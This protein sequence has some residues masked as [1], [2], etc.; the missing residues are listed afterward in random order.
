MVVAQEKQPLIISEIKFIGN[1]VTKERILLR[2]FPHTL[3]DTLEK[4]NVEK[5]LARVQSNLMNTQ[6]FNVVNVNSFFF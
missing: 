4:E 2:E 6:L 3:G 5:F 1:K